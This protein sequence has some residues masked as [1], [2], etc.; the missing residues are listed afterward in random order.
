MKTA[1]VLAG[2][3]GLRL[4]PK[5]D[6]VPKPMML[7]NGRPILENIF[8]LIASLGI[9]NTIAIVAYKEEQIKD[10]FGDGRRH[11]LNIKYISNLNINDRSKSGLSDAIFMV[12]GFFEGPFLAMLGDEIY[13]N[14]RHAEMLKTFERFNEDE[15][16]AMIGVFKTENIEEVRKNYTLRVNEK[17]DALDLEEKPEKPWNDLIGCGTYIFRPSVFGYIEKT[18]LS[19]RSGRKELADTMKLM[20]KEGKKVKAFPLGGAYININYREDFEK[21]ENLLKGK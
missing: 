21:A 2:G 1:V 10:Y 7:I 19:A 5:D 4:N 8:G 17:W 18:P 16:E 15:C 13:V 6:E 12:K 20:V 11:G 3:R 9:K 14:T